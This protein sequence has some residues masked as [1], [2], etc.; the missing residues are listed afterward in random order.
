MD[1]ILPF[2]LP[3]TTCTVHHHIHPLLLP[4]LGASSEIGQ[5]LCEL[6]DDDVVGAESGGLAGVRAG[7]DISLGPA[8]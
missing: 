8:N 1:C 7:F 2:H 6:S 4:V 3:L 5:D